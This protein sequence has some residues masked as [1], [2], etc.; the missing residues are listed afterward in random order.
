MNNPKLVQNM[1]RFL[2]EF[3]TVLD[4]DSFFKI[5]IYLLRDEQATP[6]GIRKLLKDLSF[7]EISEN[8]PLI[9]KESFKNTYKKYMNRDNK[10]IN[11]ILNLD[12]EKGGF[13]LLN[14]LH[15]NYIVP[16][17]IAKYPLPSYAGLPYTT[18]SRLVLK[19]YLCLYFLIADWKKSIIRTSYLSKIKNN[20]YVSYTP[21]DYFH[22]N[23]PKENFSFYYIDVFFKKLSSKKQTF[24]S[25]KYNRLLFLC[26]I[27]LSTRGFDPV[28][29]YSIYRQ[30]H[31]ERIENQP[32]FYDIF[33]QLSNRLSNKKTTPVF[34]F[35]CENF[36]SKNNNYISLLKQLFF[37]ENLS[38]IPELPKYRLIFAKDLSTMKTYEFLSDTDWT[39]FFEYI[40]QI[41]ILASKLDCTAGKQDYKLLHNPP[42]PS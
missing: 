9:G 14:L 31:T 26:P 37:L 12:D 10:K 19:K 20:S 33:S 27:V 24:S 39:I 13:Q 34:I 22:T 16:I 30:F 3:A 23:F 4:T 6:V 18:W 28:P 5:K 25:R 8:Y 35:N 7:E 41:H 38:K 36:P 1:K 32:D 11:L 29:K 42:S 40:Q 21:C 2:S 15:L 17:I